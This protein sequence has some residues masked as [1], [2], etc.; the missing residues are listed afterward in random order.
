[1][2]IALRAWR[3]VW[4]PCDKVRSRMY[5]LDLPTLHP[6]LMLFHCDGSRMETHDTVLDG[7]PALVLFK[8][9][10]VDNINR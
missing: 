5:F 10:A 3:L 1:M 7:G 9:S 4:L 2:P 8:Q 6:H